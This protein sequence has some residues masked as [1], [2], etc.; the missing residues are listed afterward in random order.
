MLFLNIYSI[1]TLPIICDTLTKEKNMEYIIK[2]KNHPQSQIF[3]I[4]QFFSWRKFSDVILVADGKSINC[5]KI[6][7][8]SAS[9]YF[10]VSKL[11]S[12]II[13]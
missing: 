1:L 7:L 11:E 3:S 6:I 10:F 9:E 5:H 2:W 8:S 4:S 13:K 12:I